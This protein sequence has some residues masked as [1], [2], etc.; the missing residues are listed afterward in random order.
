ML[1]F[2]S[3]FRLRLVVVERSEG[4]CG[5]ECRA[6]LLEVFFLRTNDN[7]VEFAQTCTGRDEVTADDVLLHTYERVALARDG[8]LVEHLRC[9]LEGGCRHEA[10][11]TEGCTGDTL[12][13]LGGRSRHCIARLNRQRYETIPYASTLNSYIQRARTWYTERLVWMDDTITRMDISTH[14]KAVP[15]V[16]GRHAPLYYNLQGDCT[17]HTSQRNQHRCR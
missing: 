16:A 14:V 10:L 3:A 12:Q 6:M 4:G 2:F 15:D 11:G 17:D 1:R 7:L 5:V 13:D 9:L 8:C